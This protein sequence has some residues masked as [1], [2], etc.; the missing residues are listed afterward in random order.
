MRGSH[1]RKPG[2]AGIAQGRAVKPPKNRR[3][4]WMNEQLTPALPQRLP[5][6]RRRGETPPAIRRCTTWIGSGGNAR[7]LWNSHPALPR[8]RNN[9]ESRL[10]KNS[11]LSRKSW[12]RTPVRRYAVG[13]FAANHDAPEAAGTVDPFRIPGFVLASASRDDPPGPDGV[14][15]PG[16]GPCFRAWN[17][18]VTS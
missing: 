5:R 15:R 17:R 14:V 8:G 2:A 1:R 12:R 10:G 18:S 7:K 11:K 4:G 9:Q 3:K 13:A 16:P 6:L